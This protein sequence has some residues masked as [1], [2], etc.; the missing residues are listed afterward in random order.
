MQQQTERKRQTPFP[1]PARSA[2]SRGTPR[3]RP[4]YPATPN[5]VRTS[6]PP[7]KEATAVKSTA[8]R[9]IPL[10][11]LEEIGRNMSVFEYQDEILLV[12]MGLQFPEETTPGID[13]II[14]NVESLIPKRKNI[15]GI[16][17]THG[18]YDHIGA[19]PY[20]LDK[21]GATIPIYTTDLT[22]EIIKK[23]QE[24][25][26]HAAKPII[27]TVK[28][29]DSVRISE[30]LQVDFF[31]IEHTIPDSIG[32]LIRTP[33]GNFAYCTDLKIDFDA[34]GNP[35]HLDVFKDISARGVHTLFLDSTAAERPGHSLSEEIVYGNLEELIN[36]A[37]GRIII[38]LFSSLLTRAGEIIKMAERLDKKVFLSGMSL[39]TNIQIAQNLGYIKVK[40]GTII[41]MEEIHKYKD[42]KILVL[43]TG[44]QGEPNASLMKIAN[45]ENKYIS[46]KN[47]DTIIFSSSIIPGNEMAIQNLKDSLTRQGARVIQTQHIDIHSG[48]HG[49]AEDLKMIIQLIK[50][51]FFIP[52]H[53]MYF[54]R[55]ANTQLAQ[56]TGVPQK[57]C[58]L[59]D[60]GQVVEIEADKI[61]VTEETV[62]ANYIMVDGLGVGDV[63]EVVLRDRQALSKEGM[64]VIIV[65]LDRKSGRFLKNP[66]II[67]RGF[68]N[69][70]N[71]KDF[72]EEIRKRIKVIVNR[73]PRFQSVESDY[74][75]ALI[76]DQLGQFLHVKTKRRPMVLPVVIEV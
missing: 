56:E 37:Q 46:V 33:A 47:T 60:N 13:Y 11:G 52:I 14:P 12:D 25:F 8:V 21:L 43:S 36:K 20:L 50:P 28:H 5:R 6:M 55:A 48:G 41:P 54:M 65:T 4:A 27:N 39:K 31:D 64:V 35:K 29:G 76:R 69:L 26:S 30:H 75:K 61:R 9:F 66:D 53:G 3:M 45:G 24:D 63:E 70:K 38:G 44:A 59:V 22:R 19:I 62:P 15:K 40:K 57:N 34:Q 68:I 16:I 1:R 73:I 42:N 17:I 7:Q 10:G 2:A 58:V 51:K 74:L 18:H 67:S 23:R 32:L 72:V 49:P 71:N